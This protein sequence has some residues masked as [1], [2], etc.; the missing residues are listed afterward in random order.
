MSLWSLSHHFQSLLSFNIPKPLT[1]HLLETCL[2]KAVVPTGSLCFLDKEKWLAGKCIKMS[3]WVTCCLKVILIL[4]LSTPLPISRYWATMQW[5]EN[6]LPKPPIHNN[7]ASTYTLNMFS[8]GWNGNPLQY[9]CLENPM[10]R[11]AWR[12][13]VHHVTKSWTQLSD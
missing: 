4:T 7:S 6:V 11:G 3:G 9:S 13:T 5:K 8:G 2:T 1:H 12:A 10:D